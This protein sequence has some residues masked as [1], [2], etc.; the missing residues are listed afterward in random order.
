MMVSDFRSSKSIRMLSR[1]DEL[2]GGKVLPGIR[3]PL[4]ELFL[5]SAPNG[6]VA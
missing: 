5:E 1:T 6:P 3:L 2:G 4:A